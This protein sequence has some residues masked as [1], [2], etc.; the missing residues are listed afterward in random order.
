MTPIRVIRNMNV[1]SVMV[2]VSPGKLQSNSGHYECYESWGI[3]GFLGLESA[4]SLKI[5]S[6]RVDSN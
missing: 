4:K 2:D 5:Y 3:I 1:A 6:G